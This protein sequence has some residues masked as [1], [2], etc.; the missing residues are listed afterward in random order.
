VDRRVLE[1]IASRAGSTF[2][3]TQPDLFTSLA[4][5]AFVDVAIHTGRPITLSGRSAHSNG[6]A[7]VSESGAQALE[8]Y[9]R[10][11]GPYELHATLSQEIPLRANLVLD[12]FL[13]VRDAFP[14]LYAGT[15]F[16]H[17][18]GLAFL[19]KWGLVSR[20]LVLERRRKIREKLPFNSTKFLGWWAF[21][22]ATSWRRSLLNAVGTKG[23]GGTPPGDVFSFAQAYDVWFSKTP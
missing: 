1:Q 5:P 4:V 13:V 10:E 11:Y 18:A 2:R 15:P 19:C 3:S 17:D 22:S 16:N 9:I 12:A 23:P 21:F 8:R 6:A 20:A 14:Q 7:L